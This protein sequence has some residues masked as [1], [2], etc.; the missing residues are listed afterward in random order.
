MIRP[1]RKE[2]NRSSLSYMGIP[3]KFHDTTL[4]DFKVSGKLID[5]KQR[6]ADYIKGLN[7]MFDNNVG[8]FFS[9]SNGVGKTMLSCIILKS[10]YAQRY[11]CR[12]VTFA[13]YISHYTRLWDV[14]GEEHDT[15]EDTFYNNYKAVEFLVLE[16]VGKE[17]D[18]KIATPVLE[19]LLRYRE[20][21]GLVTIICTNLG[22]KDFE[23][24]YGASC[25]SLVKGNMF[26]IEIEY[27]DFRVCAFNERSD[28]RVKG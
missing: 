17:I 2:L 13:E 16:E 24:K 9:G 28:S 3:A 23:S 26:P 14:R 25:Y 10:A 4:S 18:S 27:T 6:V 22:M 20:D 8:I 1:P 15:A 12:R 21:K 11:S 5:V 7:N 19:D